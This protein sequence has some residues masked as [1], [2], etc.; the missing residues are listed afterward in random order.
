MAVAK[1]HVDHSLGLSTGQ[2]ELIMG[3]L[4]LV[5]AFGGTSRNDLRDDMAKGDLIM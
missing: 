2:S 5:A 1:K 3:A 4:N